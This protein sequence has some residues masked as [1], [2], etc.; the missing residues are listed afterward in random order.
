MLV[1]QVEDLYKMPLTEEK[2]QG[3]NYIIAT[4]I[5]ENNLSMPIHIVPLIADAKG[6]CI[7]EANGIKLFYS[8]DKVVYLVVFDD[9]DTGI[10]PDLKETVTDWTVWLGPGNSISTIDE[11][12]KHRGVN[13][14][15]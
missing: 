2:K 1:R 11:L 8:D 10:P 5:T 12:M 6:E 9:E 7:M 15:Q 13:F 3:V 14:K 4:E